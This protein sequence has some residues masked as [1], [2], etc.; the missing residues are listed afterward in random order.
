MNPYTT[1]YY[2]NEPNSSTNLTNR[3]NKNV[4]S[5][6]KKRNTSMKTM[7]EMDGSEL[8]LQQSWVV[9]F[10][11]SHLNDWSKKSYKKIVS[12]HT[13][14]GFWE[15]Y[16]YIQPVLNKGIFFIMKDGVLPMWE[17][18]EN[19]GG[20]AI[21]FLSPEPGMWKEL[22]MALVGNQF[23]DNGNTLNG[24]SRCQKRNNGLFKL[25]MKH[26]SDPILSDEYDFPVDQFKKKIYTDDKTFSG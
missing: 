6:N 23:I 26:T 9:W 11:A 10:H 8:Q 18:D 4:R 7:N 25:W 24:I 20:C 14:K 15:A 16:N 21:S 22:C 1:V 2:S 5:M 17:H 12:F 13:I 19:S 3:T